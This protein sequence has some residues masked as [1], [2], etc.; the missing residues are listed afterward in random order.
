VAEHVFDTTS[1]E[2][3]HTGNIFALRRDHVLMPGGTIA[4]REIVEHYGA[5]AIVA[6]DGDGNIPMVYQ[7]RHAFGRRLWELPAGL[8]DVAGEPPNLAAV[9]ELGE[10]VGLQASTWQVLVDLDSAPGFS[11]ESVRVYLA[12]G[13]SEVARPEAHHEEADMKMRWFP[14]EEW[15]PRPRYRLRRLLLEG[16]D[17]QRGLQCR[18]AWQRGRLLRLRDR[19]SR[20]GPDLLLFLAA[21]LH[22][23]PRHAEVGARRRCGAR[24]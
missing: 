21:D 5:V 23:L 15:H 8:I 13:L 16:R 4:V 17:H 9:R 12:T 14:I 24:A 7:Y 2:T 10:E 19:D 6:M 11:D 1:S 3:L 20:R 18:D 22:D